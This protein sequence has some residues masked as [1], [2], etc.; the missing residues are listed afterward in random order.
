MSRF[1]SCALRCVA[2]WLG[3]SLLLLIGCQGGGSMFRGTT[4][5][6]RVQ[7][8]SESPV[9]LTGRFD[10]QIYSDAASAETTFLLT[11]TTL[12]ALLDGTMQRAQIVHIELLWL[13]RAGRTPMSADATNVSIRYIV[14]ADGEVG[15]YGG[16]GFAMPKG[17]I[18]SRR[19]SID[20]RDA[21]LK[22]LDRTDGFVDLL[23]PA[24]VSGTVTAEY[25]P[26]GTRTIHYAVSQFVTDKLGRSIFV[27]ATDSRLPLAQAGGLCR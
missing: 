9:T 13:P 26:R 25:D 5:T 11:D 6:L 7:S 24:R 15:V 17:T 18:G 16:A 19:M 23:T 27:D 10:K 22:L 12:E 14:I 1:E 2:V 3:L 4:A 8:L 21:S 20:L